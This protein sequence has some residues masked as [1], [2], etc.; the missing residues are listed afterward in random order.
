MDSGVNWGS[1]AAC[2]RTLSAHINTSKPIKCAPF[3][4]R[5]TQRPEVSTIGCYVC[6]NYPAR[7]HL[8]P[9]FGEHS[10]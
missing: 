5:E 8:H 6:L 1:C 3:V 2:G 7:A 9:M 10:Y 4:K